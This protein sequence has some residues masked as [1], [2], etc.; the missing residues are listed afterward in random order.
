MQCSGL[1]IWSA[2]GDKN[3]VVGVAVDDE[4]G[5]HLDTCK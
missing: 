2:T 3:I 1:C 4:D 5:V